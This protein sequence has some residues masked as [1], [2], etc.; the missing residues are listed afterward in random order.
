[1]VRS[2]ESF[3]YFLSISESTGP[4]QWEHL[5]Q[6]KP[7]HDPFIHTTIAPRG[8]RVALAVLRGR[9]KLFVKVHGTDE[10]HRAVFQSDYTPRHPRW[11]G[12][13]DMTTLRSR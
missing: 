11:V 6:N 12:S 5:D 9:Y 10:A 13:S 1:M 7:L 2:S 4:R 8:W 3:N